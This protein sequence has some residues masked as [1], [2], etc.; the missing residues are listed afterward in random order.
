[1]I[2]LTLSPLISEGRRMILTDNETKID[3]LNNEAIAATI[4]ELLRA[5]PA[6]LEQLFGCAT[7]ITLV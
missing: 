5:M 1:M 4:F 2:E 7:V 6:H 3:R